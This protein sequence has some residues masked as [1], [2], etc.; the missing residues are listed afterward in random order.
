MKMRRLAW[1][2]VGLVACATAVPVAAE[3]RVEPSDTFD[4]TTFL[5]SRSDAQ[6]QSFHF[7]GLNAHKF[8]V[9]KTGRYRIR[10]SN[11]AGMSDNYR[12]NAW[13]KDGDGELV[14][15]QEAF[16]QAGGLDMAVT[17]EPGDYVL[18]S[19]GKDFGQSKRLGNRYSISVA[20]LSAEGNRLSSDES[21]ID[22][23]SGVGFGISKDGSSTAFVHSADAVTSLAAPQ[24]VIADAAPTTDSDR[25]V[26]DELPASDR[27]APPTTFKE[28]ITDVAMM[29][30]G[31]VLNFEV[32]APGDVSITTA[33]MIGKEGTYRI[34]AKLLDAEGQVIAS[35][36]GERFEGDISITTR[37]A[38]G[39]YTIWVNGHR[40]GNINE[41]ANNYALHVRQL[42]RE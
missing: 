7:G 28:I 13:L 1:M 34:E 41:G 20:G 9:E 30:R 2:V 16:G 12:I 33:T 27:Q 31:E 32:E 14:A 26:A 23:G 10:S 11:S 6:S 25:D 40:Y 18:E 21:G 15:Q 19:R 3:R 29:T 36:K 24:A 38:P 37:L 17:L 4:L 42:T 5:P 35:D 8:T 22:D 39:R